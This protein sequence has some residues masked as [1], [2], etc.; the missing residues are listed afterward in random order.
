MTSSTPTRSLVFQREVSSARG[1][2]GGI[3][4]VLIFATS[5]AG[6]CA[7]SVGASW[8]LVQ[9][10]GIVVL[11]TLGLPLAI[12]VLKQ[13][14][15]IV[16]PINIFFF[17]CI[18]FFVLDM[19]LLREV[20]EFRP[21]LIFLADIVIVVFLV[22]VTTTF[23]LMPIQRS[24]LS[25][26]LDK[27]D[28]KFSSNTYFWLA[29]SAFGFEYFR[30]FYLVN[31]SISS[32]IDDLV[33]S[34][35]GGAFRRTSTAGDWFIF[36][37]PIEIFF[38][39]VPFFADRAWKYGVSQ[40][41]KFILLGV[42]ILQL[43]TL[44]IDGIRGNLLLAIMLPLFIRAMQ[45]DPIVGRW[46]RSL[47]LV[48][49][50]LSPI[51]DVMMQIRYYGWAQLFRA[52]KISWNIIQSHRD[53][54]FFWVVNL[55]DHVERN[56]GVL[57]Y[58]GPLGFIEGAREIGWLWLIA[59]IPRVF[60]PEKPLVTEMGDETRAW[61]VTDSAAGTLMRSGG[62]TCV[63]FGGILLGIW[64]SLL[65]ALY[66]KQKNDR[67][68]IAYAFLLAATLATIRSLTPWQAVPLLLIFVLIVIGWG[69]VRFLQ[70]LSLRLSYRS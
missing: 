56:G 21:E 57:G 33:L 47:I 67:A 41:R 28:G 65:V 46:L 31:W 4:L 22:A 66:Q 63:A 68:S 2:L 34:R 45:R 60:W 10:L 62:I 48:S 16:S 35:S 44:V 29:L 30:R 64:L 18:Y 53:D 61:Y 14:Y 49:F 15:T 52:E 11:L 50:I 58:K 19:A 55:V 26:V 40:S 17:G 39:G 9:V 20:E 27:V 23:F 37:Q 69:G 42:V 59:P 36:L 13:P 24:P 43:A 3:P 1:F 54:N 32:F 25:A 8:L 51:M 6:V 7:A 5:L 70:Q 12:S 38:R